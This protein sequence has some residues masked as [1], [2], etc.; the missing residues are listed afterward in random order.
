MMCPHC[1]H[2][3]SRVT[4]TRSGAEADR[5]IRLCRHCGKTFQTLERVCVYA[6]R[7]IGYIEKVGRLDEQEVADVA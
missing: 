6:G 5:R 1:N 4:E 7:A 3:E 2:P